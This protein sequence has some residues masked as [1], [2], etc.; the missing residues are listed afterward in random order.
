MTP[1]INID[2]D[3][4]DAITIDG[5]DVS[6]V[7]VDGTQ[8]FSAIPDGIVDNFEDADADAPGIYGANED[9]STYYPNKN[10][11]SYHSRTT[12]NV[13]Q[14]S[15]AVEYVSGSAVTET[16]WSLPGDGLNTYPSDGDLVGFLIR[17]GSSTAY[18]VGLMVE[19]SA[20]P[21]AY[22]F[23]HNVSSGLIRINKVND[24]S[25]SNITNDQTELSQTSVSLTTDWFWAEVQLPSSSDSTITFEIYNVDSNLN[26]G[27]LVG[28]TTANDSSF[29]GGS[30][31]AFSEFTGGGGGE[32]FADWIRIL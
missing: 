4:V 17:S 7:T 2:G 26:R 9:I 6:E 13:L 5:A 20:S 12:T 21:G 3:T 14:G 22:F 18:G 24:L 23:E 29:L 32:T 27:S 31:V 11:D 16:N 28:S 19:D 15:K 25:L 10:G 30:G 1:P 8:V